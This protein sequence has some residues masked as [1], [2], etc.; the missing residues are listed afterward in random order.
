LL[1]VP[2]SVTALI[3]SLQRSISEGR[4]SAALSILPDLERHLDRLRHL[5]EKLSGLSQSVP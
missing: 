1:R 2:S 5:E 3:E 4:W